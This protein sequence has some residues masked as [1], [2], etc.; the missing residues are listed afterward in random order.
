MRDLPAELAFHTRVTLDDVYCEGITKVTAEDIAAAQQMGFVIKL[1]A[2]E[3][4]FI[5]LIWPLWQLV[6]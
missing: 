2:V 1:L 4:Y 5:V 6:P 3:C